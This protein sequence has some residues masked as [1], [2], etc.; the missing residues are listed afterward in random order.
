MRD[1]EFLSLFFNE[2]EEICISDTQYAHLSITQEYFLS[3]DDIVLM[4]SVTAK[5]PDPKPRKVSKS[6]MVLL[7]INPI[8]GTRKDSNVTSF[9]SFLVELDGGTILQQREIVKYIGLPYSCC[10]FSGNK[11]LHY[12][13][14][15]DEDLLTLKEYKFYAEWILNIIKG[16]D[17]LTKNPSRCIRFPGRVRKDGK[18]MV[19]SLVEIKGRVNKRYFI[20]WL[21]KFPQHRPKIV[22]IERSTSPPDPRKLPIWLLEEFSKGLDFSDGRNNTWFKIA[23]RMNLANFTK[24]QTVDIL[25]NYFEE[26][27]DFPRS[28]FLNC[29]DSAY[30]DR[31]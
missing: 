10:V 11:S 25:S 12:G 19:Q 5:N 21:N 15:L 7:A 20:E 18:G 2:G 24:E 22:T 29:I 6:D 4:P 27:I 13:V 26:E 17:Q 30:K 9:R 16:A 31:I 1:N 28:E 3:N 8:K 14:V 23:G